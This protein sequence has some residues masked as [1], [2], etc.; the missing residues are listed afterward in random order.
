MSHEFLSTKTFQIVKKLKSGKKM[1][2]WAA[3]AAAGG[4][5]AAAVGAGWS[6][7]SYRKFYFLPFYSLILCLFLF[8]SWY[9]LNIKKFSPA[10]YLSLFFLLVF[11]NRANGNGIHDDRSTTSK[12]LSIHFHKLCWKFLWTI[13]VT[14]NWTL[15][16]CFTNGGQIY[17]YPG[18]IVGALITQAKQNMQKQIQKSYY[19]HHR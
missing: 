9:R 2:L 4:A 14:I 3:G 6:P 18:Y 10:F 5:T 19:R 13:V 16:H 17:S 8:S 12:R 15:C 7:T 1:I 11:L